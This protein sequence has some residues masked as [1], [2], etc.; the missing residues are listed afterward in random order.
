MA[1]EPMFWIFW[2]VVF[3]MIA[4]YIGKDETNG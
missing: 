4:Y 2:V 3:T 1:E